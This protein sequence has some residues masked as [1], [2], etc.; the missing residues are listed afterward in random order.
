M[1]F[2]RED[3]AIIKG[4]LKRGYNQQSI[5]ACFGGL[6]NSGRVSEI[7]TGKRC[8]DVQAAPESELPPPG[9]YP[10]GVSYRPRPQKISFNNDSKF[11]IQLS[12]SLMREQK[13]A[14]VLGNGK[15]ELKS[16][17]WQWERT[18]N[19]CIEYLQNGNPSGIDVTEAD[20]WVH[21]LRREDKTLVYLFLPVAR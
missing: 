16:E 11:D 8:P 7:N 9:P 19:I 20:T 4:M 14:D 13:L 12:Q 17:N 3:A 10:R 5:A 21:E 18:G 2:S 6:H 1:A 15:I